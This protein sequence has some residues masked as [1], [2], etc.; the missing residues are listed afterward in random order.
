MTL[1]NYVR[2]MIEGRE[3]GFLAL[4]I[5]PF[6]KVLSVFYGAASEWKRGFYLRNPRKSESL[7][8]PVVSVGNITWGG[9]GKT[10]ITMHLGRFFLSE[11]ATPLILTRGYGSDE[12]H[13]YKAELPNALLGIGKNR[14]EIARDILKTHRPQV[15]IM[16]DGFQHWRL[17]RDLEI[18]VV[19]ALNP[20]GN[21]E[22]IPAGILRE[23]PESLGRAHIIIFNDVNLLPRKNF[24]EIKKEV[25]ALA[26]KAE[27]LEAQREP[28]YFYY[29]N[30]RSRLELD[31][32][33]GKR[34]TTFSGVGTP[35]SFQLLIAQLGLKAARNFEFC[36]HHVFSEKELREVLEVK[37]SSESEQIITTEKDFFRCE[38]SIKTIL[39]PLILK[40]SLRIIVGDTILKDRLR[41]LLNDKMQPSVISPGK[42]KLHA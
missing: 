31:K 35:R 4:L 25:R 20:F 10:P 21:R 36:D 17:K 29:A 7:P 41:R 26:P 14:T 18:V 23:R 22:L 37:M 3:K 28:L 39:N 12:H 9:V 34:V 33:R 32:L 6:L 42:E 24:E 15:A 16:D 8:I 19:N 5:R 38:E 27:L 40:T 2:L 11:R 30:S 13:E 1:R